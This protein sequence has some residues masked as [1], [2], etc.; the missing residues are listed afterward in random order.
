M[1]LPGWPGGDVDAIRRASD[2]WAKLQSDLNGVVSA[3]QP[4]MT[5]TFTNWEG[6][7]AVKFETVWAKFIDTHTKAAEGAGSVSEQLGKYADALEEAHRKYEHMVEAMAATAVVGFGLM[8]VTGGL[9]AAAGAA[10]EATV[11]AEVASR[12]SMRAVRS[13]QSRS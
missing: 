6:E 13:R 11:A 1:G 5:T 8:I 12:P 2:A 9:S 4:P 10:T 3:T 7:A